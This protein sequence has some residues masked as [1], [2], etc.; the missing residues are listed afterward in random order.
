[1]CVLWQII[2][3][4]IVVALSILLGGSS[5][6]CLSRGSWAQSDRIE[7]ENSQDADDLVVEVTPESEP[8]SEPL[9]NRGTFTYKNV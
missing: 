3:T 6:V 2:C 7:D 4:T 1:M 9:P 5:L 8:Q